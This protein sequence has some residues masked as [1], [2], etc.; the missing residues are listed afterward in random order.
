[1]REAGL[2]EGVSYVKRSDGGHRPSPAAASRDVV[3]AAPLRGV[4]VVCLR[5]AA[6]NRA[7]ATRLR[8]DGASVRHVAPWRIEL[9]NDPEQRARLRAALDAAQCVFTSPNAVRAAAR[10]ADLPTMRARAWG[11]GAGTAAVLRQHGVRAPGHPEVQANSEGVLEL[12]VWSGRPDRVGLVTAP[13][14]RDLIEPGLRARGWRV[15]R[16]DVYRRHALPL[17]EAERGRLRALPSP[18]WLVVTSA[19]AWRIVGDA[20]AVAPAGWQ[21]LAGSARMA[22]ML[23]E[24]GMQAVHAA[25]GASPAALHEA[26]R[27]HALHTGFR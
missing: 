2:K 12:D 1:M 24:E 11:V 16:A 20:F 4:H 18:R 27:H 5:P 21:V 17:G 14:G 25:A 10:L 19:E 26:L 22:A 6:D 15:L 23:R 9:S 13:G 7:L 3:I 8:R